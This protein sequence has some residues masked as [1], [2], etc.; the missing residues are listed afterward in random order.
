[1]IYMKR[2]FF[3]RKLLLSHLQPGKNQQ[4][5]SFLLLLL[6]RKLFVILSF[7]IFCP[8]EAFCHGDSY[9]DKE[10]ET[11]LKVLEQALL[12]SPE[13]LDKTEDYKIL[14]F[15]EIDGHKIYLDEGFWRLT[16]AWL[17][18]YIEEIEKY[19]PCDLDPDL[20]L[21]E[22]KNYLA[23][24][25]LLNAGKKHG[26]QLLSTVINWS[27]RYGYTFAQMKL[28]VEVVESMLLGPF[29]VACNVSDVL[30]VVFVR[31]VQRYFRSFYY[32][33]KFGVGS[34]R[35]AAK[36][37]KLFRKVKKR[38][39][40]ISFYI[41]QA[42]V[43][44]EQELAKVNQEVPGDPRLLWI[45]NLKKKTDPLFQQIAEWEEER[46]KSPSPRARMAFT[47]KIKKAK[48]KIEELS[49]IKR[50]DFFGTGF[51]RFLFWKFGKGLSGHH[52]QDKVLGTGVLKRTMS[53]AFSF[54]ENIMEQ[55]LESPSSISEKRSIEIK[56]DEI[57]E[58]LIEEFLLKRDQA[59]GLPEGDGRKNFLQHLLWDIDQIFNTE[60]P[61]A[62]RMMKANSVEE[63]LGTTL[64]ALYFELSSEIFIR[65]Y[66]LSSMEQKR[67]NLAFNR[68]FGLIDDFSDFLSVVSTIKDKK[69]IQF[70][71]Y[72]SMEK[73]LAFFD[74]AHEVQVL[75]KADSSHIDKQA[76][77]ERLKSKHHQLQSLS[78]LR[79]K[80][81]VLG[82]RRPVSRVL[83]LVKPFPRCEKLVEKYQ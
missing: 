74:Y 39:K 18:I 38:Q 31:T 21:E 17:K 51:K 24:S 60:A 34:L 23:Q 56:P 58:G 59:G 77:F 71:K 81:T 12:F 11:A 27:G 63:F 64:F 65:K 7:L 52:L 22:A 15:Y 69:K 72:E 44:R 29:H 16:R 33:N 5:R 50:K 43:F 26:G 76:V 36:R 75:L 53:W 57:R 28:N 42:L 20:M 4:N 61:P 40:E 73:L 46:D 78:L 49:K 67:L 10:V 62:Y 48:E 41:E 70:Y 47:K 9:P 30:I 55:A 25:P 19:C 66:N 83:P 8:L 13:F 45:E 68:F 79:K 6:K 1:M 82:I 80:K 14:P 32:G 35:T 54:Q 3:Y 37:A 2:Y